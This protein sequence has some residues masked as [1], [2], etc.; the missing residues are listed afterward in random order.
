MSLKRI[1]IC[2]FIKVHAEKWM[3]PK[4]LDI[5]CKILSW[6]IQR[7]WPQSKGNWWEKSPTKLNDR[8]QR[9][10]TQLTKYYSPVD[11]RYNA[12]VKFLQVVKKFI[13]ICLP[14]KNGFPL[15]KNADKIAVKVSFQTFEITPHKFWHRI[16][17]S[18]RILSVDRHQRTRKQSIS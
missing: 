12:R 16:R 5:K 14:N 9:L 1:K 17:K 6:L 10:S 15:H 11:K 4:N 13:T 2:I 3:E 18:L 7:C 8:W